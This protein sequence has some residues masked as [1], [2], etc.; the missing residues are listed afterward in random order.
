MNCFVCVFIFLLGGD[1][2][3]AQ[4]PS[5]SDQ[6]QLFAKVAD[7]TVVILSGKGAGRLRGVATG[8][9]ISSDGIILSAWHAVKG[10]QEVQVRMSTGEVFDHVELIGTDERRDVAALKVT[11]SEL[12]FL[13]AADTSPAQGN[14]VYAVTNSNGLAFS[15][16]AGI[17]SAVRP[18]EEVPGAG[19]GYRLL[20]FTAPVAPGA[21]GGALVNNKE[22]IV[23]IIT[24]GMQGGAA[25]AVPIENVVGLP[26]SG[27]RVLL[28]SG[29]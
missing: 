4:Q 13:K 1:I 14:P 15:A 26:G 11:A 16:T 10:A 29:A 3:R 27:Q 18:A 6:Q 24:G 5:A 2:C 8:V 20:Q 9:V 17:I 23:G 28:G 12:S 21:S 25:F 22:E 7:A 19:S